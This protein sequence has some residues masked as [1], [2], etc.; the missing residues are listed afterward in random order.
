MKSYIKIFGPPHLKVL[1]ELE[2]IAVDMPQVC[3]WDTLI[4]RDIPSHLAKDVGGMTVKRARADWV[5]TYY[6]KHSVVVPVER[7]QSIISSSGD[8]LGEYD[9]FYE[10]LEGPSM[11][12]LK[13]LIEKID[14]ALEPLGC[15]YTLTTQ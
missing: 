8:I 14:D 4:S 6:E 5:G 1:I 10:W 2:K 15:R 12:Q 11:E 13:L 3:I 9:F 7:C